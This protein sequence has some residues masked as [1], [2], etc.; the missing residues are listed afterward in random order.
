[1]N[2]GMQEWL[3]ELESFGMRWERL[4]DE[5]ESGQMNVKRIMEWL[6]AAYGRGYNDANKPDNIQ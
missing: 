2:Q 3:T 4:L 1:M 5:Y 6:D